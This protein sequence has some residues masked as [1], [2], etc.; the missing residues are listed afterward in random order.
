MNKIKLLDLMKQS[1]GAV[2]DDGSIK[3]WD[4]IDFTPAQPVWQQVHVDRLVAFLRNSDSASANI[5]AFLLEKKNS[6]NLVIYSV[7]EV[8]EE[9][10][11]NPITVQRVFKTL[12]QSDDLRKIKHG[13][14]QINPSIIA[15]G[16][17]KYS[18]LRHEWQAG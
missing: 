14:Y 13:V 9:V 2:L 12:Y 4:E 1:P 3:P 5:L 10:C 17:Q 18:Q 15:Y 11:V 7:R 6:N 16:G 8:A